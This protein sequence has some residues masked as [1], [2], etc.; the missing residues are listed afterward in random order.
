MK[1]L[2]LCLLLFSLAAVF[3]TSARAQAECSHFSETTLRGID[4]QHARMLY[5]SEAQTRRIAL[6]NIIT[7]GRPCFG[8]VTFERVVPPLLDLYENGADEERALARAALEAVADGQAL[9]KLQ[10][11]A[12][13][14]VA[15][16]QQSRVPEGAGDA[17]SCV[18]IQ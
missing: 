1:H 3:G 12:A 4:R 17:S 15:A 14:E 10:D 8:R 11:H 6:Q 9:R 5:S 18:T 16:T 7:L 13:D 2:S